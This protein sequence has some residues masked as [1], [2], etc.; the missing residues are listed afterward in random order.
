MF[1][2]SGPAQAGK[3]GV[4][5]KLVLLAVGLAGIAGATPIDLRLFVQPI[6]VCGTAGDH[7][8]NGMRE[9]L[10]SFDNRIYAQAGIEVDFRPFLQWWSPGAGEVLSQQD[11][12]RM[13]GE[14]RGP[15]LAVFFVWDL[16]SDFGVSAGISNGSSRA[17]IAQV[18]FDQQRVDTI[19]HE[20]GHSLGLSHVSDPFNL[21]APG[22][23]RVEPLNLDEA[24]T[25]A[26]FLTAGQIATIRS[27]SL[28][29]AAVP[30]P[31][32]WSAVF[33]ALAFIGAAGGGRRD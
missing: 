13:W 31:G 9:T 11:L 3:I 26:D 8:A 14:A 18:V 5:M 6:Q 28:L 12:D 17:A 7:C 1:V 25:A 23:L 4:A 29:T 15:E 2:R 33:A 21:M 27:S 10:G 20:I 32:L 30:E 16:P 24:G 22:G 19:A